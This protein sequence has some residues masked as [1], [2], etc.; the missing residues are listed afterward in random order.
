MCPWKPLALALPLAACATASAPDPAQPRAVPSPVQQVGAVERW[1]GDAPLLIVAE[2]ELA[3]ATPAARPADV[4]TDVVLHVQQVLRDGLDSGLRDDD[5][6]WIQI[7]GGQLDDQII[8]SSDAPILFEGDSVLARMDVG[9]EGPI[10]TGLT[11]V[12]PFVEGAVR[13]CVN[14]TPEAM[15]RCEGAGVIVHPDLPAFEQADEVTTIP[16]GDL[17]EALR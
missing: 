16:M 1:A 7:P 11:D 13:A 5:R 10:F 3:E 6:I 4:R 9:D 2:I 17:V 8:V 14:P 15:D 12:L